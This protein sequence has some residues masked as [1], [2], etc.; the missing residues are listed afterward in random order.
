MAV[1]SDVLCLETGRS[2]TKSKAIWVQGFPGAGNGWSKP[3]GGWW[4]ALPLAQTEYAAENCLVSFSVVGHQKCLLGR[5]RVRLTP[6]WQ[7][8]REV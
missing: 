2:V 3:D 6:G 1:F 4:D 5:E 7:A 8:K